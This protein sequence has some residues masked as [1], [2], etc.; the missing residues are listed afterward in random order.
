MSGSS[1]KPVLIVGG[2]GVVGSL[3]ARTL[4]QMQPDLP[5]AIGGRSLEKAAAVAEQVGN[6]VA[7]QVDLADALLGLSDPDGFSAVVMFLKD[8]T[9]HALRF[10]QAARIPYIDISTA[11]FE[12]APEV[13]LH[14]ARPDGAPILL[15]GTWLAGAAVLPALHYA[16]EFEHIR[17]IR[18]GAVLDEQ[19]MGGPAALADFER[20][21]AATPNALILK[22]GAWT[23]VGGEAGQRVFIGSDGHENLAQA[24]SLLDA[25]YLAAAL[26]LEEARFDLAYGVSA[27]RRAGGAFSTEI[28]VEV[29]GR[30]RGG[31]QGAFRLVLTHAQGQAPVTAVGVSVAIERM[32]GLVGGPPAPAGLHLPST[33]VEPAYMV[34]RLQQH[35]VVIRRD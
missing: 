21:T 19:D 5:L 11:A 24:Y 29:E 31:G 9:L 1:Q 35:G 15:N 12:I 26:D 2:S 33:L 13:A 14:V 18:I 6:A 32:L 27:G 7:V 28:V 22:D 34:E 4:R 20:Q 25:M 8:S 17:S 30:K 3:T 23:W 10:A 16:R